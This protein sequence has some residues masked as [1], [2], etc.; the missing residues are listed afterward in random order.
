MGRRLDV[1]TLVRHARQQKEVHSVRKKEGLVEPFSSIEIYI[2]VNCIVVP[3]NRKVTKEFS[4]FLPR[5]CGRGGSFVFRIITVCVMC[6]LGDC[7]K[8]I[9]LFIDRDGDRVTGE[10]QSTVVSGC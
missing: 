2:T 3:G 6:L 9:V 1:E 5:F 4:K 7:D 8:L 10:K